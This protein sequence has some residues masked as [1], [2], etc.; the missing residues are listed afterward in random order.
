MINYEGFASKLALTKCHVYHGLHL[1]CIH[2][3]RDVLDFLKIAR[4]LNLTE[5]RAEYLDLTTYEF[6]ATHF[7]CVVVAIFAIFNLD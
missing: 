5:A 1:S 4:S 6:F 3:V 7:V 2:P